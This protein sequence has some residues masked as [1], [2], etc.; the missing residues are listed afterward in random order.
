MTFFLQVSPPEP[1]PWAGRTI[2]LFQCTRCWDA[3][4]NQLRAPGAGRTFAE[5]DEVGVD[6]DDSWVAN[7]GMHSRVVVA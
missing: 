2:A 7:A 1:H 6:I 4:P 5:V 3:T